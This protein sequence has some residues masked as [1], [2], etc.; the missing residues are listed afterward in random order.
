L[1]GVETTI[2]LSS[3]EYRLTLLVLRPSGTS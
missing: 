1:S 3:E 2:D